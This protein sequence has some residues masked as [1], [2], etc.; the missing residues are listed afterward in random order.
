MAGQ[1]DAAQSDGGGA[2]G[3]YEREFVP[4]KDPSGFKNVSGMC[5]GERTA[6]TDLMIGPLFVAAGVSAF[7]VVV[8]FFMSNALAVLSWVLL[9]APIATRS[10]LTLYYHLE[11]VCERSRVTLYNLAN[12]VMF[13]FLAG[14]MIAIVAAYGCKVVAAVGGISAP[15]MT[16]VFLVFGPAVWVSSNSSLPQARRS[17]HWAASGTW[18]P[19]TSGKVGTRFPAR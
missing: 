13:C 6:G 15:W 17:G 16:L 9:C 5:A 1:S 8:G 19:R 10:Q 14:A 7:D 3:Q 2:G 18:F 12:G 11:K 4:A